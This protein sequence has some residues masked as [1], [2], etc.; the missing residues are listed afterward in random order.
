MPNNNHVNHLQSH[1]DTIRADNNINTIWELFIEAYKDLNPERFHPD[2]HEIVNGVFPT[3]DF[4]A[5]LDEH[6]TLIQEY[7]RLAEINE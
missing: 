5:F 4:F 6:K 2:N 1:I 3:N 7:Y